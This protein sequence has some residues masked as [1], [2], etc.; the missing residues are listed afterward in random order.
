MT[1]KLPIIAIR[2]PERSRGTLFQR[3]AGQL[4]KG[5]RSAKRGPPS[6]RVGTTEGALVILSALFAELVAILLIYAIWSMRA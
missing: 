4:L 6:A 1:E 3:F 5:G 2:R